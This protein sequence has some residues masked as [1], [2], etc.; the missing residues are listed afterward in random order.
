MTDLFRM[1]MKWSALAVS[2]SILLFIL[3]LRV[4]G[5]TIGVPASAFGL[6]LDWTPWFFWVLLLSATIGAVFFLRHRDVISIILFAVSLAGLIVH[7]WWYGALR[8]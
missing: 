5:L 8:Y 3:Y 1:A 2:L 7:A 6:Y 4:G